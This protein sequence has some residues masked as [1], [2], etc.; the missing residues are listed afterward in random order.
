MKANQDRGLH[1][2][3]PL[4]PLQKRLPNQPLALLRVIV[5]YALV[6][7]PVLELAFEKVLRDHLG[8][9]RQHPVEEARRRE[10][11]RRRRE[12][13]Q[14]LEPALVDHPRGCVDF[15]E[16]NRQKAVHKERAGQGRIPP[17]PE[18]GEER[19]GRGAAVDGRVERE[20]RVDQGGL[21]WKAKVE[22]CVEGK[23]EGGVG[24]WGELGRVERSG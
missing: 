24:E 7:G 17:R 18:E 22:V 15:F 23:V 6:V 20:G 3:Q 8:R 4:A 11:G 5:G 13:H 1:S 19:V 9:D 21:E 16:V 14:R 12:K 2:L 10:V